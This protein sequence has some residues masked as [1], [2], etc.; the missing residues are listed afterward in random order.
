MPGIPQ[1]RGKSRCRLLRLHGVFMPH[2][3]HEAGVD[4][5]RESFNGFFQDGVFFKRGKE[6]QQVGFHADPVRDLPAQRDQQPDHQ[7]KPRTGQHRLQDGLT[8]K[9]GVPQRRAV[10]WK[11][12][13]HGVRFG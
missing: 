2:Q 3:K 5:L 6:A 12:R 13:C 11:T 10:R 1:G 9:A 7:R 4:L 8:Q